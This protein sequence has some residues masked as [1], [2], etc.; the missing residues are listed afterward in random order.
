MRRKVATNKYFNNFNDK[1]EQRLYEDLLHEC[2][3]TYGIDALYLVR[4]SES[5]IDLLFGEDP[6]SKFTRSYPVE[7]YVQSV[8]NFEGGELFSKFGLEVKKQAR[9]LIMNRA[10]Q[11]SVA[12]ESPSNYPHQTDITTQYINQ[13]AVKILFRPREGDLLWMKNFHALFEI[14]FCDE[15]HLFYTFG[16][17][18]IY[19]YSMVCEKFRYSNERIVTG[20]ADLDDT[21]NSVIPAFNF[22]MVANGAGAFTE[23]EL[24]YQPGANATVISWDLPSLTLTL[25]HINGIF[26]VNTAIVGQNSRASYVLASTAIID[27]VNRNLDNNAQLEAEGQSIINFSEDNPFATPDMQE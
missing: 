8:D 17:S 12:A 27:D 24:V 11:N 2:V 14:K 21:I 3:Q 1:A 26:H 16:N 9:F 25:K 19:G 20:V 15:E 13:N 22:T 7:V 23:G 18:K 5:Q 10:F 4:D 6:T